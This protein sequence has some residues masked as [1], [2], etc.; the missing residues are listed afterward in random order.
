MGHHAITF[1]DL[2]KRI[3]TIGG[4]VVK[5]PPAPAGE[6]W[7]FGKG[8]GSFPWTRGP[9]YPI[10]HRADNDLI[11]GVMVEKILKKLGLDQQD[12][13]AFWNIET[14]RRSL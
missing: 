11:P 14:H 13:E 2:L 3:L 12:Q 8:R 9:I 10:R 1:S 5:S 7:L 6:V 4:H